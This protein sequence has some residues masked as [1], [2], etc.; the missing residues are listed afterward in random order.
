MSGPAEAHDRPL[1]RG[2]EPAS[3]GELERVL[4]ASQEGSALFQQSVRGGSR[5]SSSVGY[6]DDHKLPNLTISARVVVAKVV[7]GKGRATGVEVITEQGRSTISA[8]K[9]VILTA[10]VFGSPQ[11]LMLSGVGPAAHLRQHGIAV[12]ADLPVGDNPHDHLFVPMTYVMKSARNRGT[13]PYF[14]GGVIKE[15]VRGG[16]WMARSVFEAVGFVRSSRAGEIPDLLVRPATA[17]TGHR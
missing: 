16:T 10:G 14:A 3:A 1:D 8:S 2:G 13:T 15:T 17:P 7:I 4:G 11:I 12:A 5:Y 6:L 9:E